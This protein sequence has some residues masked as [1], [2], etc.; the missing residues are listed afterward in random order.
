MFG[1]MPRRRAVPAMPTIVE[2]MKPVLER[3]TRYQSAGL[4]M[5][6]V[7]ET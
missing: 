1:L 6:R 4:A 3:S 2:R 5:A 7:K